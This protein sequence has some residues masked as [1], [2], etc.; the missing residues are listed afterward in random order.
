MD[1]ESV[2]SKAELWPRMGKTNLRFLGTAVTISR[3]KKKLL[4]CPSSRPRPIFKKT[5]KSANAQCAATLERQKETSAAFP[6]CFC[7]ITGRKMF[8]DMIHSRLWFCF[9]L[10]LPIPSYRPIFAP[11]LI[12]LTN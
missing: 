6:F 11:K 8:S 2:Y 9:F 5:R 1:G 10:Y 12:I 3:F 7:I 4:N